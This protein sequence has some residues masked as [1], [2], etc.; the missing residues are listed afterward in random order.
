MTASVNGVQRTLARTRGTS[1]LQLDVGG[2]PTETAAVY[3]VLQTPGGSVST[4]QIVALD[5]W[6]YIPQQNGQPGQSPPTICA[7]VP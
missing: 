2:Q 5:Y 6:N 7:R 1:P 3:F 4:A